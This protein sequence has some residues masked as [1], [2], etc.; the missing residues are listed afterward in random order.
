MIA[1]S[2][3]PGA[4]ERSPGGR[5]RRRRPSPT[6]HPSHAPLQRRTRATRQPTASRRRRQH[7]AA[8]RSEEAHLPRAGGARAAAA[9]RPGSAATSLRPPRLLRSGW[10]RR[11]LSRRHRTPRGSSALSPRRRPAASRPCRCAPPL[12]PPRARSR[13][14]RASCRA[15]AARRAASPRRGSDCSSAHQPAPRAAR[16]GAGAAA[17]R[18][19][20]PRSCPPRV[21][22]RGRAVPRR[23]VR[24]AHCSVRHRLAERSRRRPRSSAGTRGGAGARERA[25]LGRGRRAI[26]A[27][28]HP[29]VEAATAPLWMA[30][31]GCHRRH[32]QLA[33]AVAPR[34]CPRSARCPLARVAQAPPHR[35]S[36]SH[37]GAG[38]PPC[39]R[40]ATCLQRGRRQTPSGPPPAGSAASC[41]GRADAAACREAA[42][43]GRRR[44]HVQPRATARLRA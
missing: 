18:S 11:C 13:A 23:E 22:G 1:T 21:D 17:S 25:R 32:S 29:P 8:A 34:E 42:K 9:P 24:S 43:A 30:P 27:T 7:R 2:P 31:A 28:R 10:G 12:P 38:S 35:G 26:A 40:S 20:R 36:S 4:A 6:R 33:T 19:G 5:T 41:P 16:Q 14:A 44:Q 3:S 39:P 37:D 15:S